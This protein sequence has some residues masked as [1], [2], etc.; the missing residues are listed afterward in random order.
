VWPAK[1]PVPTQWHRLLRTRN[2]ALLTQSPRTG[3]PLEGRVAI[4]VLIRTNFTTF[5]WRVYVRWGTKHSGYHPLFSH[6]LHTLG[7][8]WEKR[9]CLGY[10]TGT[11]DAIIEVFCPCKRAHVWWFG[12][13]GT[14]TSH[15]GKASRERRAVVRFVLGLAGAGSVGTPVARGGIATGFVCSGA[16]LLLVT[17][18]SR[19]ISSREGYVSTT[20]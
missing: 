9:G 4:Q 2:F 12:I 10:R 7:K 17:P 19:G 15:H 14:N 13:K 3:T 1:E 8:G 16:L 20:R 5:V 6:P 18:A 11:L